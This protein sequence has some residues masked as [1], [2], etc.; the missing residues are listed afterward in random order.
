[1]STQADKTSTGVIATIVVV[2]AFSMISI[3]ALLTALV[4]SEEREV[5]STRPTS[6]DLVTVSELKRAQRQTLAAPPAWKD[7]DKKRVTMPIDAAMKVV[8]A[9]YKSDPDSASPPVPPGLVMPGAA[10]A[11]GAVPA[12]GAGPA[13]GAVPAASAGPEE[14]AAAPEAAAPSVGQAAPAAGAPH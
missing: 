6:A 4:R 13:T 1:M 10:A 7:K 9:Q 11:G 3:S 2:G 14:P 12:A 5:E 8:L